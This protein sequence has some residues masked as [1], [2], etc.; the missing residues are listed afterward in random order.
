MTPKFTGK[1]T[2]ISS[3]ITGEI[4]RSIAPSGGIIRSAE[5]GRTFANGGTVVVFPVPPFGVRSVSA[6]NATQPEGGTVLPF[7]DLSLREA[8]EEIVAACI[9]S[10]DAL[11]V[12]LGVLPVDDFRSEVAADLR[13]IFYTLAGWYENGTYNPDENFNR[14][15]S[16]SEASTNNNRDYEAW[17]GLLDMLFC[18]GTNVPGYVEELCRAV[19]HDK[20]LADAAVAAA[21]AWRN[22]TKLRDSLARQT[23]PPSAPPRRK[24][25]RPQKEGGFM[26][27]ISI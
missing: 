25:K 11:E 1:Y 21:S 17:H 24:P 8:E 15:L 5:T 3:I 9:E 22:E 6:T 20:A 26:G 12:C 4:R 23:P 14:L 7:K 2:S 27:G 19:T 10:S 13:I 18:P 16:L